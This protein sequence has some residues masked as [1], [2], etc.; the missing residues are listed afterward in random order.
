MKDNI[1]PIQKLIT[2][3]EGQNQILNEIIKNP[4]LHNKKE[5]QKLVEDLEKTQ[6]KLEQKFEC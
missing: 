6:A 4:E 3:I 2:G 1:K 5:L